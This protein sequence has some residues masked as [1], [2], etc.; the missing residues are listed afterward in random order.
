MKEGGVVNGQLGTQTK[1]MR[2]LL[3][4]N[5]FL[6]KKNGQLNLQR[7]FWETLPQLCGMKRLGFFHPWCRFAHT[8]SASQVMWHCGRQNLADLRP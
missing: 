4:G 5:P 3:H 8:A 7:D 1:S 2:C 6:Y